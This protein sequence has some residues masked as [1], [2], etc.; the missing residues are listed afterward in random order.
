MP[1]TDYYKLLEINKTASDE[2]LKRA[3]RKLA[4]KYHPDRTKG[5]K[6]AEEQFKKVSEAYAVLSDKEKRK[7]YDEFG[8]DGFRKRYTQ[9][10][11]FKGADLGDILR[12]FGFGGAN[13]FSG[14]GGG[15]RFSYNARNAGG[16]FGRQPQ[17]P[18]KGSDLVYE[19][20][21][22]LQEVVTGTSKTLTLQHQG[23][24][25]TVTVKVPKGMVTGKKLRL[26]GKGEPSPFGGP[27]GDLYI[28][29]RL[30]E[31][32]LFEVDG[33]NVYINQKIKLSD[34]LLGATM[35]VPTLEG[36]EVSLKIPPGTQH[37]TNMRLSGRGIPF[38]Q[39]SGRG[40][41]FV[42]IIINMPKD[43]TDK[44][45]E[46]LEQLQELGL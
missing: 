38:M 45:K 33:Y 10:D 29:A 34:A 2:E 15:R 11:I 26:A 32:P 5:D 25:E 31:D 16:P 3:Y 7:Q 21:L 30:L 13:F 17:A 44:Q 39:G 6:V 20:G 18:V 4:M 24:A 36:K 28:K 14:A 9:E 42:R 37:R 19:L 35:S 22:S 46:L 41:L 40:D 43:L 8:A 12:E 23:Q 1:E 27:A